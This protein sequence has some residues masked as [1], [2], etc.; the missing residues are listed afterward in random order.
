MRKLIT[1]L[2]L[3]ATTLLHAQDTL[4]GIVN[5]YARVLQID[6]CQA[7]LIVADATGNFEPGQVVLLHQAKGATIMENNA[8][9]FG[10]ILS[11]GSAGHFEQNEIKA[12][13]ADTVWLRFTLS[14]PYDAA[15]AV[16]LVGM[17]MVSGPVLLGNIEA[18]PWNGAYGGILA[19]RVIGQASL[20]QSISVDGLGF[21]DGLRDEVVSNCN[22]LT[23]ANAYYYP[24]GNW[25]GAPKG[26]GV[27]AF[28][29]G[30]EH[31]RGPQANGGGGGND[32]NSGG[33]G[34]ANA[35]TGGL[36]GKHS[37][38]GT[39]GCRGNYPGMGGRS[40][41]TDSLRMFF[42][43]EGGNGH[44]DDHNAG[45]PGGRGG[46]I[47]VLQI[48]TLIASGQTISAN[49][50]TPPLAQGDGAGGGGAGGTIYLQAEHVAGLLHLEA[51]GGNGGDVVN[52]ADRCFGPGGGGG[53]GRITLAD[54]PF[55][56]GGRKRRHPGQEHQSLLAVQHLGKR[57]NGWLGWSDRHLVRPDSIHRRGQ[58]LRGHR[59]TRLPN[60][61]PGRHC[62]S[63]FP[64][65]RQLS[66]FSVATPPRRCLD[67]RR[68]GPA[69]PMEVSHRSQR[70]RPLRG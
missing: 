18:L 59:P 15:Q 40:L 26:E 58:G 51:R 29:A 2:A 3:L 19:L 8:G 22:F 42:G 46:G 55:R 1:L 30:K 24:A 10:V 67:R 28:I 9:D 48:D 32:H 13:S 16:Q 62:H 5:T 6:P 57:R 38:P 65:R 23:M 50:L 52:P 37:P 20:L 47:V 54:K 14:H 34:G 25:R 70:H 41:L 27:A 35:G 39:F 7:M 66:E 11:L 36:G 63:P 60:L 68:R 49:G 53:G 56:H 64:G 21:G 45:S 4:N 31:G 61:L 43:G 44:I 33:G 69:T 12:V 17:P